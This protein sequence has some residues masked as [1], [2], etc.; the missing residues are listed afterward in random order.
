VTLV[1]G[2]AAIVGAGWLDSPAPTGVAPAGSPTNPQ[3]ARQCLRPLDVPVTPGAG[4][5]LVPVPGY[6]PPPNPA[7]AGILVRFPDSAGTMLAVGRAGPA[8]GV[9][10][11]DLDQ[12]GRVAAAGLP[13]AL[14][15]L[16][17]W[18]RFDPARTAVVVDIAESREAVVNG[19][20]S[21]TDNP[22]LHDV[23]GRVAPAAA[24]VEATWSDGQ[25]VTAV[26]ED[27][28]FAARH[29]VP[30]HDTSIPQLTVT[31]R[32]YDAHG[33]LLGSATAGG[34]LPTN[35]GIPTGTPTNPATSHR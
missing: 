24:R 34:Y 28:V 10:R 23:I 20:T 11:C 1:G 31:V 5:S 35:T 13:P 14:N 30:R 9:A 7:G 26:I 17:A 32:A 18:K 27:G 4:G 2:A 29:V 8:G 12:R 15:D 33:R 22:A 19:A 6:R 16:Q 25:R 21:G 3:L